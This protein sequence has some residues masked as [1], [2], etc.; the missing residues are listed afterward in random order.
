M[1][2]T[3]LL[4]HVPTDH[5]YLEFEKGYFH[6]LPKFQASEWNHN[7]YDRGYTGGGL[8]SNVCHSHLKMFNLFNIRHLLSLLYKASF[9][10][11]APEVQVSIL[12]KKYEDCWP[13]VQVRWISGKG[14][15][16]VSWSSRRTTTQKVKTS[17]FKLFE[18]WD[19]ACF[20]Q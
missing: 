6:L 12:L 1:N 18:L 10:E 8:D 13:Q 16:R 19:Q 11:A 9:K 4:F 3:Y 15:V 7:L 2:F 17:H 20:P 14:K 5:L